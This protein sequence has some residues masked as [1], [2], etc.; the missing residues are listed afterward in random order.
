[1]KISVLGDSHCRV[2][3]NTNVFTP[4]FLGPGSKF[5]LI[6]NSKGIKTK[7]KGLLKEI[8]KKYD[9]NMLIFGEPSCRYQVNNDHYIYSKNF[10]RYDVVNEEHLKIMVDRYEDI[11]TTFKDYNLIVCA[12]ISVYAQSIKFSNIFSSKI[13]KICEK[14]NIQFIDIKNEIINDDG[15]VD[16]DYKSD[17]IHASQKVLK[18]IEKSLN[19]IDINIKIEII[20]SESF[21]EIKNKYK[22]NQKFNCYVY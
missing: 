6:Q 5:N 1:M 19:E 18:F 10:E 14:N 7:L 13:K 17:P 22:F 12:P 8:G 11:I 9:Y 2:F 15:F 16:E 4:F 3:S 20:K 21:K